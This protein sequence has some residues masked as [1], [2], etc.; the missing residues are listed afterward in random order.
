MEEKVK[1]EVDLVF[2]SKNLKLSSHGIDIGAVF[3]LRRQKVVD[4]YGD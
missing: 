2:R 1:C 4:F 3:V